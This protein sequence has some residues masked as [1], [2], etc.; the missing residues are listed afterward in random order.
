MTGR[1]KFALSLLSVLL[2]AA[3]VRAQPAPAP[4]SPGPAPPP[5]APAAQEPDRGSAAP[6][7]SPLSVSA[8]RLEARKLLDDAEQAP[9]RR[10]KARSLEAA[11]RLY[12]APA[13]LYNLGMLW[14]GAGKRVEAAD[15]LRRYLY[16]ADRSVSPDR[17]D[18]LSKL[19]AKSTKGTGELELSGE[20]CSFVYADGRLVGRMPLSLPLLL[21]T[22]AH[23]IEVEK[24][25]RKRKIEMTV[26]PGL[27][28]HSVRLPSSAALLSSGAPEPISAA[29][30]GALAE[31]GLLPIAQKARDAILAA[32]PSLRGCLGTLPCQEELAKLLSAQYLL[33]L[34]LQGERVTLRLLDAEVGSWSVG[35]E[36]TC[37]GCSQDAL[38]QRVLELSRD[39]VREA[40]G[41]GRGT[42]QITAVPEADVVV[43]GR[44]VGRTP[45]L[46]AALS[47][48]HSVA[49]HAT[50]YLPHRVPVEVE[51]GKRHVIDVTLKTDAAPPVA[52]AAPPPPVQRAEPAPPPPPRPAAPAPSR[53]RWRI[54]LG[55]AT[56]IVGAG[57]L[58]FGSLAL[59]INGQC[60]PASMPAVPAAGGACDRSYQTGG[61]G[62]ALIG[63]GATLIL[64]GVLTAAWP[65]KAERTERGD[66]ADATDSNDRAERERR[67]ERAHSPDRPLALVP[68]SAPSYATDR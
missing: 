8:A 6:N 26:E 36:A 16:E 51:D 63:G 5:A 68:G 47:G 10:S 46:R 34:Q 27:R 29:A 52:A 61:P 60:G 50:G 13:M 45:L 18:R 28:A 19:L 66:R 20:P 30:E 67:A 57:L 22:G 25:H 58:T 9:S 56:A 54:G 2:L 32:T 31:A 44:R 33:E 64:G 11:Y 43:D 48:A 15:L 24:D 3:P 40:L 7:C 35:R 17:R 65:G 62:G 55:V 49:L 23:V 21:H 38:A 4:A 39:A 59:S 37:S 42:L 12:Q 53:P 41:R 1:E 14:L